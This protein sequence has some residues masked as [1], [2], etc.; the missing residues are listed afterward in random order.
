MV[1]GTTVIGAL[2]QSA[3][4]RLSKQYAAQDRAAFGLLLLKLLGIGALLGGGGVFVAL[5]AG[6]PLLTLLYQP[7]YANHTDVFVWLMLASAILYLASFL[8]YGVTAARYFN[9][10]PVI[11]G[12]CAGASAL[13]CLLL[14]PPY[15][16][17]GAAW[18]M[19]LAS[20]LQLA[21]MAFY[22][23]RVL[24]RPVPEAIARG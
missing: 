13:F 18:A 8:G 12:V 6:R 20:T 11:F 2:G 24:Y 10:Q 3:S 9:V 23:A 19:I 4:P 14:I 22:M 5:I 15:G 21:L 1:A 16:I 17:Q 7:E